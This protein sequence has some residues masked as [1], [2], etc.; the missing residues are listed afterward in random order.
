MKWRASTQRIGVYSDPFPTYRAVAMPV[1]EQIMD[2]EQLPAPRVCNHDHKHQDTALMC[3][4]KLVK[5][6]ADGA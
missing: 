5:E 3:A 6:I 4:R 1:A 2:S